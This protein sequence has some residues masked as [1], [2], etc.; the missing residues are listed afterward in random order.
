MKKFFIIVSL[1]TS[2]VVSA[3]TTDCKGLYVGRIWVEKGVGFKAVVYLNNREDSSGSYWSTFAGWAADE[4]K[5]ALSMLMAAKLSGHRLNVT[6]ENSDGCGLQA[7]GT[8]TKELYL[9]TNL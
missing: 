9:T 3:S 5:E 6:T 2:S 1:L 7:S 4:R 8:I